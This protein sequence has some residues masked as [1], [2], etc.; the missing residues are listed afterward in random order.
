MARAGLTAEVVTRAGLEL[1]D[2]VGVERVTV[3]ELARRC[4]VQVASLYSH[5]GGL[6]DL[7]TRMALAALAELADLG[8]EALAGRSGREALIALGDVHRTYATQHPGRYDAARLPLTPEAAAAS[9][10]PRHAR[11][12][13]ACLRD[14]RMPEPDETH[15]VRLL[16]SLFH[17]YVSLERTGGFAHSAP[18]PDE[19][20]DR[21]L[22]VLDGLLRG[23][24]T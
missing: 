13:R 20:W 24:P 10:G 19:S 15:A 5:V 16:G 17:G 6:D 14:Y 2:D 12:L 8:D 22:D 9:A 7:R 11:M 1:A 3:S 4:G 23:W 18:D 21:I